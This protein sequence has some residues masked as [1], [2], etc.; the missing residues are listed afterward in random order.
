MSRRDAERLADILDAVSAIA[1]HM[2]RGGLDDGLVFDA[3]RARLIEIGE[4][5][6]GI[7]P[8]LLADEPTFHGLTSPEC[9]IAS[10]TDT[11]TPHT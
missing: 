2:K 1:D 4:A 5:V 11:S 3:V 6:K 9:V 10:R 8:A 7:T